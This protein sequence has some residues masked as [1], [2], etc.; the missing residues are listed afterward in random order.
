MT[1]GAIILDVV[2]VL[3][4]LTITFLFFYEECFKTGAITLIVSIVIIAGTI[5]FQNWYYKNT[6]MGN[7][8]LKSQKSNFENG[9]V[10]CVK[11]YDITGN[12]IQ[13]YEGKFDVTYDSS[14]IMFDD[15]NNKRHIIYY[16]TGTVTIDEK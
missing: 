5:I 12:L 8:A 14:R 6:A 11:V 7:R 15:E 1:I 16:S 3:I 9:I 10:R 4:A 13:E 2:L